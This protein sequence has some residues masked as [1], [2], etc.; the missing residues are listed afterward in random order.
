MADFRKPI[1]GADFLS[2]FQLL[3][4]LRDRTLHDY[5]TSL[6]TEISEL[7]HKVRHHVTTNGQ[8]V[9][10][11]ARRLHAD[12]LLAAKQKFQHM[13]SLGT[14]RPSNSPWPSSLH[15]VAKKNGDWRPCG[16]YRALNRITPQTVTQYRTNMISRYIS[17]ARSCFPSL[18]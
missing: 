9:F 18:I 10:A 5:V 6:Q 15:M 12:K 2:K 13:A 11:R 4:N 16:D 7:K 1:I 3:V 8:S 17:M 14:V